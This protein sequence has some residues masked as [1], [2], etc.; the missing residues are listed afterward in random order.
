[1]GTNNLTYTWEP[2]GAQP[3]TL[4]FSTN[5]SSVNAVDA[6]F[7]RFGTYALRVGVTDSSGSIVWST[8]NTVNVG[9]TLS[10]STL[11]DTNGN[12][13]GRIDLNE[14][15]DLFVTLTR[16][17]SGTNLPVSAVLS[18]TNTP[19][20]TVVQSTSDYPTAFSKFVGIDNLVPFG[21][22]ADNEL[23]DVNPRNLVLTVT[24]GG[25]SGDLLFS[26]P[27]GAPYNVTASL[28]ASIVPGT[29][30]TG[31]HAMYFGGTNVALPFAYNF[32]G[33]SFTNVF[34]NGN[35]LLQFSSQNTFNYN[36][37][38]PDAE[39]SNFIAV[40]WDLL[41]LDLPGNGIFTSV[42]GTA[43]N[44]IFNI[45]W[46]AVRYFDTNHVINCEA[47]LFESE[48]RVDMIYGTV[49][50]NGAEA[51][52]GVQI[53]PESYL[54]Y[55]S[56]EPVLTNGLQLSFVLKSDT[57][58]PIAHFAVSPTSGWAPLPVTFSDTSTGGITNRFWDFGDGTTLNTT[59]ISVSHTY[60]SAGNKTV[61]LVVSGSEG[62]STNTQVDCVQVTT[63]VAPSA[64]FTVSTNAGTVPLAVTFTDTSTG[65]ITNRFWSFGD[66]A[67][68]STTATA[69]SHTY[70]SVGTNTVQLIVSGPA[71]S[72]TNTQA[73]A[74]TVT[75]PPAPVANFSASPV[76]GMAPLAVT[77]TDTSTG[78]ITNRF[79]NF[80]DGGTTNTTATSVSHTYA[81]AGTSTVQLIVSGPGG[82]NTNTKA[83][84][85]S[86][87]AALPLYF[88]DGF[89]YPDGSA[90]RGTSTTIWSNFTSGSTPF[91][92]NRAGTLSYS[93]LP[94]SIGG[95]VQLSGYRP[96][97]NG[98]VNRTITSSYV[99]NSGLYASFI[100][101][102]TTLSTIQSNVSGMFV[103]SLKNGNGQLLITN[104]ASDA[105]KFNVGLLAAGGKVPVWYNNGG[106]GYSQSTSYLIAM[107]LTN[108]SAGATNAFSQLW[109]N[110]PLGQSTPG[111]AQLTV[112]VANITNTS[113]NVG[114]GNG[115]GIADP[116]QRSFIYLDEL[117]VGPS[118]ASVTPGTASAPA[119]V[120][121]SALSATGTVNQSFSYQIT[122]D[123]SPSSFNATGLPS[124]LSVNT[125]SGAITGTPTMAGSNNVTISAS[126]SGGT[127]SETLVLIINPAVPVI[128]SALSA[129]GTVNQAFSYQITADNSPS[130]F[131]AAGLPAGLS[132]NTNSG[133]ITGTPTA[134]GSNN[135][136]IS[137]S[138]AGGTD[139]ETLVVVI[140]AAAGGTDA[141]SDGI[142]DEWENQYFG[143]STN[144]NPSALAANGVNTVYETYIAG[145][146]P[147]NPASVLRISDFRPLTSQS[148][149]QWQSASGRVYS[150]YW[151]TNLMNSFQPLET[152]ILWPQNSWTDTVHGAQ[153]GSFYRIKVQLGQ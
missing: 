28:G 56:Y 9:P 139:S 70:T 30:D 13:N 76:S 44:R 2:V 82:A 73:G 78:T 117:R 150:V 111:A 136:T 3:S 121:T 131:N 46:R 35:G 53:S 64:G 19:G 147:T 106:A 148:I 96:T 132:V 109:V 95:K 58:V 32:G 138:N 153:A 141:D 124:G 12:N 23:I 94:A 126:S 81:V 72:S 57:G 1:M 38:I 17:D 93:G 88:Y 40:H 6:Y 104:N 61:Q 112:P 137:A 55:S 66:G 91:A 83:D 51:S 49:G 97:A 39:L 65:D 16:T 29:T 67:T 92:T 86:V 110:P 10:G 75:L 143:G 45:E 14:I 90:L 34:V 50:N 31:V 48:P 89:N 62:V 74:V 22:S 43:P 52:V 77:F 135:V 114:V 118:W 87:V 27:A 125:N 41:R 130:S 134:A 145:L 21:L 69:V 24:I 152:N 144:A 105:A 7:T 151:A 99:T 54:A 8:T 59:A 84:L 68:T 33:Q 113:I 120:I 4:T 20:L 140:S 149:L 133:A 98:T 142:P 15:A 128:T 5:S 71:G 18:V 11:I 80:G 103:F 127:D 79:W 26:L 37:T 107:S 63:A 146:N 102:V 100:L 122:A 123:N 47:R 60:T 115:N 25:A 116:A 101:N 108:T 85:I 119:P 129:T 36:G 42:S